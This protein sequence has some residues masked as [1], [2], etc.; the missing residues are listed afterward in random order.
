M[1]L[2]SKGFELSNIMTEYM[3]HKFSHIMRKKNEPVV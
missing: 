3:K 1:T 2:K